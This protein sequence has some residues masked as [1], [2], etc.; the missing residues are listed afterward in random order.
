VIDTAGSETADEPLE[1]AP[2]TEVDVAGHS[3]LVLQAPADRLR[4]PREN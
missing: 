1:V 2:G 4:V 3:L